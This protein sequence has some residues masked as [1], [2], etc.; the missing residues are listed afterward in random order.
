MAD[1]IVR[2]WLVDGAVSH[3][4]A[5]AAREEAISKV[6]SELGEH[7][8]TLNHGRHVSAEAAEAMGLKISRLEREPAIQDALLSVHHAFCLTFMKTTATKIIEN[9]GEK[10]V[11]MF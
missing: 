9:H 11:V 10:A 5:G 6:L 1:K 8:N 3:H 2:A 7:K 4:A